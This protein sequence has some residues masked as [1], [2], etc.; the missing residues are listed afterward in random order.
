MC[1]HACLLQFVFVSTSQSFKGVPTD[2]ECDSGGNFGGEISVC[3][4]SNHLMDGVMGVGS[5]VD[6]TQFSAWNRTATPISRIYFCFPPC[7]D[8]KQ[9]LHQTD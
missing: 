6:F 8:S 1:V 9:F 2:P 3:S 4:A 7:R 5:P